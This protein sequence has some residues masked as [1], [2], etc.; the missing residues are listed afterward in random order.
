MAYTIKEKTPKKSTM[1]Y[2][3]DYLGGRKYAVAFGTKKEAEN[4]AKAIRKTPRIK[5]AKYSVV[6]V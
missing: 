3:Q 2:F 5:S 1:L 4:L 6:K